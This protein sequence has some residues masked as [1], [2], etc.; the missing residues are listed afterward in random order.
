MS[1]NV[2]TVVTNIDLGRLDDGDLNSLEAFLGQYEEQY[3]QAEIRKA[4]TDLK[5]GNYTGRI[6]KV[7]F[8][9]LPDGS[10]YMLK[11][12]IEVL[13]AKE[14]SNNDEI[15]NTTQVTQWINPANSATIEDELGRIKQ[16]LYNMGIE[17]TN[18][19]VL[20]NKAKS[21]LPALVGSEVRFQVKHNK[22]TKD[23][24]KVFVNTYING[25]IS[26]PKTKTAVVN[27]TSEVLEVANNAND[28][29]IP[30]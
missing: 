11:Y 6:T 1:A 26:K 19:A 27:S 15:G 24:S 18:P 16:T 12:E 14:F 25:L 28:D 22:S 2:N 13:T 23:E 8:D 30:F 9:K 21:P 17:I 20:A 4:V 10:K 7:G 5:E 29:D 3:K